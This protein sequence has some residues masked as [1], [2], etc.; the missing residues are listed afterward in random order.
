MPTAMENAYWKA[1]LTYIQDATQLDS[2]LSGLE[3]TATQA[4]A[5]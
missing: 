2:I 1:M 3:A 4:Y 5:S